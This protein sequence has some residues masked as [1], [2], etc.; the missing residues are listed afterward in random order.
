MTESFHGDDKLVGFPTQP[1]LPSTLGL[2]DA[3]KGL[4]PTRGFSLLNHPPSL[5]HLQAESVD[6]QKPQCIALWRGLRYCL[7]S[8][9]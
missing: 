7:S 2:G 4:P 8:N 5:S 6:S 9:P 3:S 1:S